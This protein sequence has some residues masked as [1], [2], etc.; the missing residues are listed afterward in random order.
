MGRD[1]QP[2]AVATVALSGAVS[3]DGGDVLDAADLHAA[4]R[5]GAKGRLG[6]RAGGLGLVA[7]STT[8]LDVEGSDAELTAPLGDVLSGQHGSVRRGLVAVSLD[9]HA[10]GDTGDGL[11]AR[12]ISDVNEG[13]VEGGVD[14]RDGEDILA[15]TDSGAKADDL[16]D[17]RRSRCCLAALLGGCCLCLSLH[18][19]KQKNEGGEEDEDEGRKRKR[20]GRPRKGKRQR[21]TGGQFQETTGE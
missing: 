15:L 21:A 6:T 9:L 11:T 7:A 20:G 4:A 17:L 12:E 19:M 10:T 16:L 2:P 13:I 5:K 14:V 8:D 18:D 3:G 1:L